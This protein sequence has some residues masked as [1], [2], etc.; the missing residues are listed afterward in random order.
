M[1]RVN[2]N[3]KRVA[4]RVVHARHDEYRLPF[5]IQLNRIIQLMLTRS[6]LVASHG[7]HG[8]WLQTATFHRIGYQRHK[9]TPITLITFL[10]YKP[11]QQSANIAISPI[12]PY[13]AASDDGEVATSINYKQ[14][15]SI[16]H[17]NQEITG[18][19]I[20]YPRI[21]IQ[22]SKRWAQTTKPPYGKI[23]EQE[24]EVEIKKK[25]KKKKKKKRINKSAMNGW[26][27]MTPQ[28]EA[29]PLAPV[30]GNRPDAAG[31]QRKRAARPQL[32]ATHLPST[33]AI[34]S[35]HLPLSLRVSVS[36]CLSLP[37]TG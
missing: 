28:R 22:D 17:F 25:K 13:R 33:V 20:K 15:A 31:N 14:T 16:I 18:K 6:A 11:T 10:V 29:Q 5:E 9:Q 34:R 23:F 32:P 8:H 19:P 2:E 3:T 30:K 12:P 1:N 21:I 35:I 7:G 26:Q 4:T 36:L 24:E 27:A 37:L